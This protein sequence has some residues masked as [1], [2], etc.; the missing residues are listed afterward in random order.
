MHAF[1][2]FISASQ[3]QQNDKQ[4]IIVQNIRNFWV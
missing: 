3:R 4:V 2:G 1:Y